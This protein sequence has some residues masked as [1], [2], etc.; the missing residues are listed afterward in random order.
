[1]SAEISSVLIAGQWRPAQAT[2]TFSATNPA[3]G[4]PLEGT[5]PTSSWEDCDAALT[6]AAAATRD[7]RSVPPDAIAGFLEG[8][9]TCIEQRSDELVAMANAETGLPASPRLRE[10]ELPRTTTQ[11]RQGAAAAREGSWANATLDTKAN[12]RS[13]LVPIGPVVIFGPNNFP[14]AFNGVSGGDFT[15]AIAA[16]NPVIAKA[17]PLHPGTS[18]LLAECAF[19]AL[20]NSGLPLTTVQ[21]LYNIRN[22]DGLRLVAD[23][24]VGA[25]SFTGSRAAGLRLKAAADAAGKP[26]YLE[27]SSLNPIVLLPGALAERGEAIATELADSA[28]AAAGQF[29]TSPNLIFAIEGDEA[30]LLSRRLAELLDSRPS[31]PLLSKGG[32]DVLEQ[33]VQSLVDAGATVV[34]GGERAGG[35]GYRFRNTLLRTDARTFFVHPQ[36]LQREAFGNSTMLV[37]ARDLSEM[38][39]L[40]DALEGNLTGSIYTSLTGG[41]DTIYSEIAAELRPRVGRL[42]NN[43]MPTGVALSPAMNHG[44]PYPATAHPGFTSVGIP[45]SMLRFAALHSYDNVR[46]D[47]LPPALRDQAPNPAM[48]RRIDGVWKQG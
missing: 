48:W 5:Y 31:S 38:Q 11:L 21:M 41:D 34:T 29:C 37:T 30:E 2:S 10:V 22:E 45:A 4:E 36:E 8:Y 33:G 3:T 23:P 25:S 20:T 43:K 16:G 13:H 40:I 17:H 32:L 39:S 7:L 14:F 12:I 44:G 18:R 15:A 26:M 27:L 46:E 1:M 9:A 42:L 35:E 28:L 24:R 6:A 19:A 47:R